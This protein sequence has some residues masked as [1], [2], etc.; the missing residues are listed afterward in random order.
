MVKQLIGC[1]I[2]GSVRK[3]RTAA[4]QNIQ[5]GKKAGSIR[6]TDGKV[7]VGYPHGVAE[8]RFD[9]VE[10][11]DIAVVKTDKQIARESADYDRQ[12]EGYR[13]TAFIAEIQ[14][15]IA[16]AR[17]H[18]KQIAVQILTELIFVTYINP[19]A[20]VT[21]YRYVRRGF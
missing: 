5:A 4:A 12:G 21:A 16:T 13:Q 3:K 2:I 8:K 9:I 10:A 14:V 17:F 20:G 6:R 15:A 1:Q 19:V 18:P 7:L 11:D